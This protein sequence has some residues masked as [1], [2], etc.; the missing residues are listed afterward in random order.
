MLALLADID[1]TEKADV[2]R[3]MVRAE[4]RRRHGEGKVKDE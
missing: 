4:Y 3:R 1:G 2:L